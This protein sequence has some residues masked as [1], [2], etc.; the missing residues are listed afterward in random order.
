MKKKNLICPVLFT[1]CMTGFNSVFAGGA[2]NSYPDM[3][4]M[5]EFL[6]GTGM[7]EEQIK[8]M[9]GMMGG[10]ADKQAAHDAAIIE[11]EKQEFEAAYGGNP[12]ARLEINENS[13][14]LRVTECKKLE[15][16]TFR[17]H[18]RQAP[19]EDDVTLGVSCCRA[20]ISG[21]GGSISAPEGISDGIPSDGNFDGR[22]FK[23]EG[24]VEFDGPDPEPYVKIDLN[25][26]GI[27]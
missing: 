4:Q 2:N 18:A 5:K 7:S 26:E 12:A 8:Q 11:K 13:Y 20:G 10:M 17:M 1:L 6:K 25:C 15:N 3:E 16:G 23:W 14:M 24:K 9:E 19:G 22:T 21:G 27:I